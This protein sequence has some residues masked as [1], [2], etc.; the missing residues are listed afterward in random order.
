MA[1]LVRQVRRVSDRETESSDWFS[2][3]VDDVA[4]DVVRDVER[5]Y[6]RR[7]GDVDT[8]L[9]AQNRIGPDGVPIARICPMEEMLGDF[10]TK[11]LQ[12]SL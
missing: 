1:T 4:R 7:R 2:P 10:Y 9:G 12:G 8:R 5:S 3:V 11:P 6:W